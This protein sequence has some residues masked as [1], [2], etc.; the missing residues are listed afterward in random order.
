MEQ[1]Y[2]RLEAALAAG[3]MTPEQFEQ[4][5][6]ATMLE[7]GG[8]YW[9]IGANSGKWYSFDGQAWVETPAPEIRQVVVESPAPVP[10]GAAWTDPV[11]GTAAPVAAA[12]APT[13]MAPSR[14]GIAAHQIVFGCGLGCVAP[15]LIGVGV[16]A[17]VRG[18][19]ADVYRPGD[20]GTAFL[21]AGV[22]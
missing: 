4:A 12:P 22:S 17:I 15:L 19:M 6:E 10:P 8:R 11:N 13:R 14:K 9:M 3:Q 2:A 5:L 18:M 20:L 7:V 1:E 16:V 21:L